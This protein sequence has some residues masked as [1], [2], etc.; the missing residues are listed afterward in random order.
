MNG[1]SSNETIYADYRFE[2]YD[3]KEGSIDGALQIQ[4]CLSALQIGSYI[5]FDNT[6]SPRRERNV[7]I[8]DLETLYVTWEYFRTNAELPPR[9]VYTGN[10]RESCVTS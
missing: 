7:I 1:I 3:S 8:N 4:N 9:T 6:H 5:L 10:D 2:K